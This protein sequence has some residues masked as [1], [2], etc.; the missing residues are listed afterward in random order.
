MGWGM[1]AGEGEG[2]G[3]AGAFV[4]CSLLL[5]NN[6]KCIHCGAFWLPG[7]SFLRPGGVWLPRAG[8]RGKEAVVCGP[9]DQVGRTLTRRWTLEEDMVGR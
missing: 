1:W 3:A 8:G 6:F 4:V 7:A 2:G 5:I 9:A